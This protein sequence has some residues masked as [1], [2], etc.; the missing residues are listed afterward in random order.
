MACLTKL[1][2]KFATGRNP[3]RSLCEMVFLCLV[4]LVCTELT[5]DVM[6]RQPTMDAGSNINPCGN[7]E[8]NTP[9]HVTAQLVRS[10]TPVQVMTGVGV[11]VLA[12][13]PPTHLA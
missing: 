13:I 12:D 4:A 7:I 2:R 10:K 11:S 3:S 5:E 6:S 9:K 1:R 8:F